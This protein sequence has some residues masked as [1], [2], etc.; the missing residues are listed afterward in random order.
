[1]SDVVDK[2]DDLI[3]DEDL[4]SMLGDGDKS[5]LEKAMQ[6]SE[7]EEADRKLEEIK[8]LAGAIETSIQGENTGSGDLDTDLQKWFD[9]EDTLPSD[10]LT[11]YVSNPT[12]KMDY[13]LTKS[14]LSNFGLMGKLKK[15]IE[16]DAFELLFTEQALMGLD[17]EDVE[18]RVKL[19]AELYTKLAALNSKIIN[20]MRNIR[21][22]SQDGTS[23]IDKLQM[24]LSSI[25][26]EKLEEILKSL[27]FGTDHKR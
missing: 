20:D 23:E 8:Q 5:E 1:M 12:V 16:D 18:G 7:E 6:D 4:L 11:H 9:G 3:N 15:F 2:S 22:K 21:L 24:L 17:P 27:S 10:N 19:A 13:G 14:T 26:S 25:P